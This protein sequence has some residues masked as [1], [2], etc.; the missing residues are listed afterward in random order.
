M[1]VPIL[2]IT[3]VL[4]SSLVSPVLAAD[5]EA[6]KS[7]AQC[8]A[9]GGVWDQP[10]DQCVRK[11][12][13]RACDLAGGVWD[14]GSST[15]GAFASSGYAQSTTGALFAYPMQ[16]QTPEQQTADRAACHDWAVAQT[17]YDPSGVYAA[18]QAGVP[19]STITNVTRRMVTPGGIAGARGKAEVRRLNE[20]YGAYLRAGQVCLEARGY[21]VSR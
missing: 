10:M 18:Q 16:G 5:V 11:S 17:G 1:K 15:C 19:M 3:M 13:H 9:G 21:Q 6:A 12:S 7:R 2:A 14:D 4:V 20:L 8:E